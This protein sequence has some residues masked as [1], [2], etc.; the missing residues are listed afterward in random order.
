MKYKLSLIILLIWAGQLLPAVDVQRDIIQPA[1]QYLGSSYCNGSASPPCFDC[2]G[3][4]YFLFK[5]HVR[6]LPR[7]SRNIARY[8]RQ[9]SK[10]DL[11]PGDLV[12]FAT[13]PAAGVISH[14]ALYIGSN[15]IIHAISDGPERGVNI[16]SLTARYWKKHYHSAA[17]IL[18][19]PPSTATASETVET[20]Q[21]AHGTYS[22][23]LKNGEPHG[24][25]TLKMNNG[26]V[27]QGEFQDGEFQ[28]QER[29]STESSESPWDS[30][31]GYVMGDYAAWRAEEQQSFED[32]KKQNN[33]D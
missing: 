2:S 20:V 10:D 16:T 1:Q 28:N 11:V 17:R 12:F 29:I 26:D 19:T 6:D 7:V 31:D 13:S 15:S 8:G 22:G 25:G 32:W 27:Y 18:S 14:V 9:I 23:E 33:P 30:W 5:P 4:I 3:F 21:F 24:Q